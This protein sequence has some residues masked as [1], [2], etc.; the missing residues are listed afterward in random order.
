MAASSLWFKFVIKRDNAL[1][2]AS[3]MCLC[4]RTIERANVNTNVSV[5]MT[6]YL[7]TEV[8][9]ARQ[10]PPAFVLLQEAAV[11]PLGNVLCAR[12]APDTSI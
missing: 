1:Q 6:D 3:V 12:K 7:K 4:V 2:E 8:G 11:I 10:P 5:S 9:Q